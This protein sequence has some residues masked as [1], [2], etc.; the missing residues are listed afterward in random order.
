MTT[1]TLHRLCSAGVL[2]RLLV[3]LLVV[4]LLLVVL[5]VASISQAADDKYSP[6]DPIASVAGEPVFL[7]E[8]NLV[9]L[10]RLQFKSLQQVPIQVQQATAALLVRQHLAR[11]ALE[12][13]GGAALQAI[14]DRGI[15]SFENDLQRRGG[16][17]AQHAEANRCNQRGLLDQLRWQIAWREYLKSRLNDKNLKLFYERNRAKYAGGRWEVSHLF[18]PVDPK[19]P[20]S[21]GISDDRIEQILKHLGDASDIITEFAAAARD[22]SEGGTARE[23]GYVGWVSKDGDLPSSVMNAVRET[24]PGA[25]STR[26]V[27]PLGRHLVLV[28]AFEPKEVAFEDLPDQSAIRR[29]ATDALFDALVGSQSSVNVQWLIG[30]LKPPAGTE[31]AP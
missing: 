29:D 10:Q 31:L 6:E 5:P 22:H 20:S 14:I 26:V 1:G 9:L 18:L 27:S 21:A 19:D 11:R 12:S 7:G 16:S 24:K 28:H 2:A 23:G 13:K 8:L 4:A 3:A 30:A 25:V 15:A 17:L